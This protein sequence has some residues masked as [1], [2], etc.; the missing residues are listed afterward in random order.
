MRAMNLLSM[1]PDAGARPASVVPPP[2]PTCFGGHW[3][4][5][6]W[7]LGCLGELWVETEC[8]ALTLAH[9]TELGPMQVHRGIARGGGPGFALRI[10]MEHCYAVAGHA[11][12]ERAASTEL[13]IE[14]NLRQ[15]LL[16]L[17][18][19]PG[20]E[21][22]RRRLGWL[23]GAHG[24]PGRR[25]VPTSFEP[26]SVRL[27]DARTH[28]LARLAGRCD[29]LDDDIAVLDMAEI[30]GLAAFDPDRLLEHGRVVGVD[31]ARIGQT[32]EGLADDRTAVHVVCGNEGVVH[33]LSFR[34][35]LAQAGPGFLYLC[36]DGVTLRLDT[37]V[38]DSACV[39]QPAG[40]P[41]G[42]QLRLY[43]ADGRAIGCFAAV[44]DVGTGK[45]GDGVPA[46]R[47]LLDA[48]I[49]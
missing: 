33:S 35:S 4:E 21:W 27:C 44:P 37:T 42:R 2:T 45:P 1:R 36:G 41:P 20:S 38:V 9:R 47:A 29:G 40:G 13:R 12:D 32:L 39:V 24:V 5:L 7:D 8:N 22:S 6:L 25:I 3:P 30:C 14:N 46:W 16:T 11:S 18:A 19:L 31:P 49:A 10:L 48:L 23:R 28:P 15:S 26:P 17:R 34:P 43:D